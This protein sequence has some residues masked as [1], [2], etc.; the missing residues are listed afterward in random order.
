[1]LE[2]KHVTSDLL[3]RIKN[4]SGGI[5]ATGPNFRKDVR[6]FWSSKKKFNFISFIN[7]KLVFH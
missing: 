3:S 4:D 5:K 1:M 7:A 6:N 2:F